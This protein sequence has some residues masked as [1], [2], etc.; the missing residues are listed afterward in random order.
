[1]GLFRRPRYD[2]KT[3]LDAAAREAT[4]GRR[5]SAI[6]LYRRVLA[7][8]PGN[9]EIHRRLAPL[10]AEDGQ[11]FDAWISFRAVARAH[12][13][14]K[15]LG[16]ARSVF[17]EAARAL[18]QR[19][20]VWLALSRLE[21]RMGREAAAFQT[22]LEGRRRMGRRR[23]EAIHL[24]R[25]ARELRPW[26]PELVLDL[27]RLLARARQRPEA[28]WLLEG[29]AERSRGAE[30]RRVRRTQWRIAPSLAHAWLWL[31]AA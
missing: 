23:P 31:R 18:P 5:R 10:L 2:R 25:Q 1:M 11:A 30:R 15:E 26:D 9:L 24:L 21:R 27:A 22:L 20:D 28:E 8:E 29:L 7:A 3:T 19:I 4:R 13:R 14:R 12:Q 6:A 17:Q 16:E